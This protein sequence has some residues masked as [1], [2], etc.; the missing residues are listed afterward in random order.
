MGVVRIT[1]DRSLGTGQW[2][3]HEIHSVKRPGEVTCLYCRKPMTSGYGT[4]WSGATEIYLHPP[5][6]MEL[7]V[8]MY[9]DVHQIELMTK[10]NVTPGTP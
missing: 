10:T 4:F 8:R 5:C 1:S 2:P 7:T 6:L 3:H 9:R